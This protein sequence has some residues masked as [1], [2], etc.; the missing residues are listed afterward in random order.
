MQLLEGVQ[1]GKPLA[2]EPFFRRLL[3]VVALLLITNHPLAINEPI[4]GE[5]DERE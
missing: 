5:A 4:A 3:V 1:K 2:T